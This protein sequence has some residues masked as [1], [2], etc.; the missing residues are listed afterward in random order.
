MASKETRRFQA[1]V[2]SE[3]FVILDTETTGLH[4]AEIVQIAV[5]DCR[6]WPMLD[7]LVLPLNPIPDAA[8]DVHGITNVAVVDASPWAEVCDHVVALIRGH[9]VIVYNADF[10]LAMLYSATTI[11]G[12]GRVEWSKIAHWYCAMKVF[13][14]IFGEW[15]TYRK[16]FRW[17]T[18]AAAVDYF[19]GHNVEG[20]HTA[21]ADCR[22]T[23]F[24]VEKIADLNL[25]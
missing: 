18:L 7:T 10:D 15:V 11:A 17:K 4:N 6:G 24:V 12:I 22:R 5:V 20:S 9:N 23:L 1:L 25:K 19:G 13:A 3:N 8:I 14:P 16:S 21:L 2:K